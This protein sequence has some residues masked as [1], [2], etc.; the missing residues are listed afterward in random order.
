MPGRLTIFSLWHSG[1]L[2]SVLRHRVPKSQTK[3]GRLASLA[4]NLL[5][6]VPILKLWANMGS[7]QPFST[8][9]RVSP[10]V[11]FSCCVR[12]KRFLYLKKIVIFIDF[13]FRSIAR[14]NYGLL[15][16]LV[17]NLCILFG[18]QTNR[19]V[20]HPKTPLPY[21]PLASPS[22]SLHLPPPQYNV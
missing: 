12:S 19:N 11:F 15:P 2:G 3:N 7:Q 5:A 20:S 13:C 17:L 21:L 18:V 16:P 22:V 10:F 8:Y 6:T 4:S 1:T 9:M 14:N